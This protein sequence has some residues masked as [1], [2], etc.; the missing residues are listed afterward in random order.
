MHPW[1]GPSASLNAPPCLPMQFPSRSSWPRK[2]QLTY[3]HRAFPVP[4]LS[5]ESWQT[6]CSQHKPASTYPGILLVWPGS[7]GC[8][9]GPLWSLPSL[10][11]QGSVGP[12][13]GVTAR[14]Q[15]QLPQGHVSRSACLGDGCLDF[16]SPKKKAESYSCPFSPSRHDRASGPPDQRQLS[17]CDLSSLPVLHLLLSTQPQDRA[18]RKGR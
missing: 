18:L 12:R 5:P 14:H 13:L 3:G 9:G 4:S 10:G 8:H 7:P 1:G 15:S 2:G 16:L 6:P 11:S 17:P